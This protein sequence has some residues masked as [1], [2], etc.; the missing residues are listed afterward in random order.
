MGAVGSTASASGSDLTELLCRCGHSIRVHDDDG[1]GETQCARCNCEIFMLPG[2]P[3]CED[4][5]EDHCFCHKY[6]NGDLMCHKCGARR[7][8]AP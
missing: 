6:S 5:G 3:E 1:T 7:V 2:V 8:L 4:I